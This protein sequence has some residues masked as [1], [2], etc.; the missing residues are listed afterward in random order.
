MQPR[1]KGLA[2]YGPA[3]AEA[4]FGQQPPIRPGVVEKVNVKCKSQG[5][6]PQ[7]MSSLVDTT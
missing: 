6:H 4:E 1:S 2:R 7:S 5:S 3:V